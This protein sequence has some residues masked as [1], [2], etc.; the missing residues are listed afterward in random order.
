MHELTNCSYLYAA[1]PKPPCGNRTF[2]EGKAS[3]KDV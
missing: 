2:S 3:D 1:K